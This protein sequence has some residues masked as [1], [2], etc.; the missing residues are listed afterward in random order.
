MLR[1]MAGVSRRGFDADA[2]RGHLAAQVRQYIRDGLL[3]ARQAPSGDAATDTAVEALISH[4]TLGALHDTHD[5][6]RVARLARA[7][8]AV[9]WLAQGA[10]LAPVFGLAGT[11][12]ALARLPAQGLEHATAM[13]AIGMAVHATL[14]GLGLAHLVLMPLA[15]RIE[16]RALA[17]EAARETVIAWLDAQLAPI[18]HAAMPAPAAALSALGAVWP[19]EKVPTENAQA[20]RRMPHGSGEERVVPPRM[21]R[22]RER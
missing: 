7:G 12:A 10:E 14:Y 1:V 5:A 17:E 6:A 13:A 16:R 9:R 3:R 21:P 11:L 20:E 19:T 18:C 4:R 22:V 15:A 8:A 2:V